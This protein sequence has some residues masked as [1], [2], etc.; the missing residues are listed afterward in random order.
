MSMEYYI[1]GVCNKKFFRYKS[2]I[3]TSNPFCSIICRSR[4]AIIQRKLES[5]IKSSITGIY[6]IKLTDNLYALVDKDDYD[7]LIKF[8]WH[9]QPASNKKGFYANRNDGF[10][11]NGRRLQVKMHRQIMNF[12]DGMDVDHIN[13][14]T[15]DNRKSNLR[16]CTHAENCQNQK[17]RGGK[18]Q[19]RGITKHKN[20]K[21]RA[22]LGLNYKR[23]HIGLFD[24]EEEAAS[25]LEIARK[26]YYG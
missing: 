14:N 12:P 15:L 6:Q 3:S 11:E 9:S 24:T 4:K 23:V 1:C 21:W 10:D 5:D 22:R 7:K 20:G 19:Y 26:K 18:S 8:N 25:A 17:S 13:G 2:T 16:I